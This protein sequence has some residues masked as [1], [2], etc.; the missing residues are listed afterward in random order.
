MP[1]I[2]ASV[3]DRMPAPARDALAWLHELDV[4]VYRAVAT[5]HTP[6]LDGPIVRLSTAANY[7]RISMAT[8]VGLFAFGGARGR[9]AALGGVVSVAATSASVNLVGKLLTRRSRPERDLHGVVVRRH[10]PMPT[11]TSFPSGHSAAAMAFATG[12]GHSWPAAA[13]PLFGLASAVAYSR[14][15]TGVHYPGDVLVGCASGVLTARL[16][17]KALD[18]A[19]ARAGGG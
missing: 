6:I 7:S 17:T 8:A 3:T 2:L 10:V 15:H 5:T 4:T 19:M 1:D 13:V 11:S 14:V 16:A 18:R 12:V 9:R